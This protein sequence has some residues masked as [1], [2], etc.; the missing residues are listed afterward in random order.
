LNHWHVLW[1]LPF[2]AAG[3]RDGRFPP[4]CGALAA[5]MSLEAVAYSL[6]PRSAFPARLARAKG[7]SQRMAERLSH[8]P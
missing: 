2:A 7:P 3:C 8:I 1:S 5:L 4:Y 6:M